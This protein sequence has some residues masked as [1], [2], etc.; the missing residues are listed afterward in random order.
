M[1]RES[2]STNLVETSNL[3]DEEGREG[4]TR[5]SRRGAFHDTTRSCLV[6]LK[7]PSTSVLLSS[8]DPRKFG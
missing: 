4:L 1:V 5:G 3:R 8:V 2:L 6:L 7:R